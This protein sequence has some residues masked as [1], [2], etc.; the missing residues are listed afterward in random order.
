M[1]I[2]SLY[3]NDSTDLLDIISSRAEEI[4]KI[5]NS[6]E[7]DPLDVEYRVGRDN[8]IREIVLYLTTGGPSIK[9]YLNRGTIEGS[10]YETQKRVHVQNEP[11]MEDL[12]QQYEPLL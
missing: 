6:S 7:I 4:E 2:D 12:K 3:T 9:L 1:E 8:N 5:K 10:S 11:L